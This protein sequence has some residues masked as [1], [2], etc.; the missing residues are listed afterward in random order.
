MREIGGSKTSF[1]QNLVVSYKVEDQR[2]DNE[3]LKTNKFVYFQ[4]DV[5]TPFDIKMEDVFESDEFLRL[6]ALCNAR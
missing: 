3:L 4:I 2:V 1:G 5:I 6:E